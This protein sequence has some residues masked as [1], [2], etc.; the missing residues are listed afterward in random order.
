M[1]FLLLDSVVD[2]CQ[3]QGMDHLS[4][5]LAEIQLVYPHMDSKVARVSQMY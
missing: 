3:Y 5:I 1:S 2:N 4:A